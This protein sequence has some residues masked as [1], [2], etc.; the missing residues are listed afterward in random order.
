M[1]TETSI[2][3]S[4]ERDRL[5]SCCRE[6]GYTAKF[7]EK[8]SFR[9]HKCERCG[10]TGHAITA[11]WSNE[12]PVVPP[13]A[14]ALALIAGSDAV[15]AVTPSFDPVP[16]AAPAATAAVANQAAAPN[17]GGLAMIV[18]EC[19]EIVA[20]ATL[21]YAGEPLPKMPHQNVMILENLLDEGLSQA[22][23]K[24]P[25]AQKRNHKAGK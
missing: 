1:K 16:A 10:K 24:Q 18:K 5:Y 17:Q 12:K 20:A 3:G 21:N 2:A 22:K 15:A 14:P 23:T 13:R 19:P 6:E 25:G 7:C 4:N 8:T 11:F 9:D